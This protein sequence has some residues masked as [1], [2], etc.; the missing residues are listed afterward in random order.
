M[1]AEPLIVGTR[2]L[3]RALLATLP[4]ADHDLES[5]ATRIRFEVGTVN[6]TVCATDRLSSVALAIVSVHDVGAFAG[7]TFDL[8]VEEVKKILAVHKPRRGSR[9]DES[10]Q[11]AEEILSLQLGADDASL[12]TR[13]VSGLF[14]G[15]EALI[16][17]TLTPTDLF[18]D[19]PGYIGEAV[20]A[21][22]RDGVEY[23]G[24]ALAVFP[25]R[26]A[27]FHAASKA[28]GAP[29]GLRLIA[30]RVDWDAPARHS[31]LITVGDSFIG[32]VRLEHP[33]AEN[34]VHPEVLAAWDGWLDRL[35]QEAARPWEK[36][37]ATEPAQDSSPDDDAP[38]ADA[39]RHL[40]PV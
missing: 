37:E 39:K 3:R 9:G 20:H 35:P 5:D 38:P 25:P 40:Q 36:P 32:L 22:D 16:V 2:D 28:Y 21:H 17:P 12:E 4:H 6:I 18:P 13:D 31:L 15:D 10:D 24:R 7:Q 8:G 11:D 33:D 26:L 1:T 27:V 34:D 19:V 29:L 23:R 14:P 30:R